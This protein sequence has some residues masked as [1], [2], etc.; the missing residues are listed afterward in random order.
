[1]ETLAL[2]GK[3]RGA[4]GSLAFLSVRVIILN[5]GLG[6]KLGPDSVMETPSFKAGLVQYREGLRTGSGV[7]AWV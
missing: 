3:K 6:P 2:M 4:F 1:M 5:Q 7:A